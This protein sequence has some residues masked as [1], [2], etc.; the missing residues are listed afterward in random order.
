MSKKVLLVLGMHRSGTSLTANWL[1]HIGISMG[2]EFVPAAVSNK[3]GHFEDLAFFELHK[4]LLRRHG[5]D[6]NGIKG[7]PE[8]FISNEDVEE[9]AQLVATRIEQNAYLA[10]KEPRTVLFL[11]A[12]L[13]LPYDIFKVIVY[14]RPEEVVDSLLRRELNKMEIKYFDK[15]SKNV[16]SKYRFKERKRVFIENFTNA[17]LKSWLQYN[18]I[19]FA[20]VKKNK[21]NTIVFS[22]SDLDRMAPTIKQK[23]NDWGFDTNGN[24]LKDI[25]EEKLLNTKPVKLKFA[26]S[27]LL[28]QC[29]KLHDKLEQVS[30]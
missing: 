1:H 22:I 18:T 25:Q 21:S 13:K 15:R 29:I 9:I 11:S 7:I 12:Y 17:Y 16:F 26:D 3:K 4:Q 20:E 19:L 27:V 28:Q 30:N 2:T 5:L 23:L 10:F 6:G 14:R 24:S 8:S